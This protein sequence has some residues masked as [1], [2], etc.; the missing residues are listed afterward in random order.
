MSYLLTNSKFR[1]AQ[2][3]LEHYIETLNTIQF[4]KATK[5]IADL[6]KCTIDPIARRGVS[7][8]I[9]R[10]D[11][12]GDIFVSVMLA[13]KLRRVL[14]QK[15]GKA[16]VYR[17]GKHKVKWIGNFLSYIQTVAKNKIT[18]YWQQDTTI[19]NLTNRLRRTL[20]EC[21]EFDLWESEDGVA[22]CGFA[23]WR[24]RNM[25][26]QSAQLERLLTSSPTLLSH[27]LDFDPHSK[28]GIS[29]AI[30]QLFHILEHP[31]LFSDVIT[32]F[33]RMTDIGNLTRSLEEEEISMISV[34]CG[35]SNLIEA[36]FL[37]GESVRQM[38]ISIC[39]YTPR[40][41]CIFMMTNHRH[42]G[43]NMISSFMSRNILYSEIAYQMDI[44]VEELFEIQERSPLTEEEMSAF[45][46][47]KGYK[48]VAI[49][50]TKEKMREQ[51][52][53]DSRIDELEACKTSSGNDS[54]PPLHRTRKSGLSTALFFLLFV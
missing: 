34:S 32:L 48:D 49:R 14:F 39:R 35:D 31:V 9:D 4:E 17:Y 24:A 38:W 12:C 45:L 46:V 33:K 11:I 20:K 52:I 2:F 51:I 29:E 19:K 6:V 10:E 8:P 47:Q 40:E 27:K 18:S 13:V 3:L 26:H 22:L 1:E 53:S 43:L 42:T 37:K 28:S 54:Q 25:P 15:L 36:Q 7:N 41:V 23:P 30:S 5:Q 21:P 44:S 16:T 50:K